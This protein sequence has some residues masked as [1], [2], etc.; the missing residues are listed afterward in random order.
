MLKLKA[1]FLFLFINLI[2]IASL[3]AQ[4]KQGE[5]FVDKNN[6]PEM[7]AEW[8]KSEDGTGMKIHPLP[9]LTCEGNNRGGG[10]Y[11]GD[12]KGLIGAWARDVISIDNM[13]PT[14][15]KEI[16]FDLDY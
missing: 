9:L 5:Y 14:G 4:D 13:V 6:V 8:T 1:I 12:E 16:V 2:V 15:F 10:D 7:S 11:R 3:S